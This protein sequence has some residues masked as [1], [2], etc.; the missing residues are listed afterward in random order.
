MVVGSTFVAELKAAL[1]DDFKIAGSEF[2]RSLGFPQLLIS[3]SGLDPLIAEMGQRV[4]RCTIRAATG[5]VRELD[6]NAH[7][8]AEDTAIRLFDALAALPNV[9]AYDYA[10]VTRFEPLDG[11][12]AEYYGLLFEVHRAGGV[13]R[14]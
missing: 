11:T 13:R 14:G 2:D 1:S 6:D 4:P 7:E 3:Y 8:L 12:A 10:G 9:L 5:Y